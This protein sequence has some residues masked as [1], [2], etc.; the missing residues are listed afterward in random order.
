MRWLDR[1]SKDKVFH[2]KMALGIEQLTVPGHHSLSIN[3]N[4]ASDGH[5]GGD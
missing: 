2:E 1:I 3:G 4:G 5:R